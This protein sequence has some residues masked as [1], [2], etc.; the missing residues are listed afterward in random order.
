VNNAKNEQKISVNTK[1]LMEKLKYQPGDPFLETIKESEYFKVSGLENHVLE[2]KEGT[3]ISIP[4]GAFRNKNGDLV[5][6]EIK[7][8]ITDVKSVEDQ[9][10]SNITSQQGGKALQSG[11]S[12]YI[13]ATQNGEQLEINEDNPIY[14]ETNVKDPESDY[15]I[16]EGI[17]NDKGEM[18]W[19]N[20]SPPKKYLIPIDLDELDFLPEGFQAAVE[21]GMPIRNHKKADQQLID[22]LYYSLSTY[23]DERVLAH[24]FAPTKED[25]TPFV[26]EEEVEEEVNNVADSTYTASPC[27][28]IDPASIKVLKTNKYSKTFIVTRDFEKRIKAIHQSKNCELLDV[29]VNNLNLNMSAL[30]SMVVRKLPENSASALKFINFAHENLGNVKNLPKS[31][32]KLGEYYSQ[33]LNETKENLKKLKNDYEKS[34]NK[35]VKQAVKI[36]NEYRNMISKRLKYRV[37][38]FGYEVKN[39]GWSNIAKVLEPLD[40]FTLDI[41]IQDGKTYDYVNV[42]TIDKRIQSIFAL[43]SNNQVL[44]NQGY[45]ADR[46]LLYK[47]LQNAISIVVAYKD[48][49]PYYASKDFTVTPDI[50]IFLSPKKI[51]K[52]KLKR[53]LRKL[54]H[55]HKG[56]NKLQVDLEFQASFYKEKVRKEKLRKERKFIKTLAN[57]VF[58]C[59][60]I[61]T[62]ENRKDIGTGI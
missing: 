42:Y 24:G 7:I 51:D 33:E 57:I 40:K 41:E 26:E 45:N 8:E 28:G 16:F 13:N 47:K 35:K 50:D 39:L 61:D 52:G 6:K 32:V 3:I 36:K 21:K 19:I 2:T 48:S 20:P 54:D 31:V 55:L 62:V 29:Y 43:T 46:F 4:K 25:S 17:R 60:E 27:K 22:S 56:F 18:Q 9:I 15:L 23:L 59:N 11:G 10:L 58:D 30:D 53:K 12:I 1:N 34:L 44:F 5:E 49:I 14:V 38:K 37:N